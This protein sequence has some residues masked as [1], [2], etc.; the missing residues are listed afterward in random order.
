MVIISHC[1]GHYDP[2]GHTLAP[3]VVN[4][5]FTLD[6]VSQSLF[7]AQYL[8]QK[9]H[10]TFFTRPE[11]RLGVLFG[12]FQSHITHFGSKTCHH[13]QYKRLYKLV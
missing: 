11:S 3:Y 12:P 5:L 1:M 2:F 6:V 8:V 13:I 9:G 10:V 4:L 7:K